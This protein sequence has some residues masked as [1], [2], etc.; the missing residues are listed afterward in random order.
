MYD[1]WDYSYERYF[2]TSI[3]SKKFEPEALDPSAFAEVYRSNEPEQLA[4]SDFIEEGLRR[5]VRQAYEQELIS[6]SK[7][8]EYLQTSL[9]DARELTGEWQQERGLGF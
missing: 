6:I 9:A 2:G 7:V 5:L 8:A 1:L 3:E 4:G